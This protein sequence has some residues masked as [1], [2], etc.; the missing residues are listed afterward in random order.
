MDA[1]ADRLVED[2]AGAWR[3]GEERATEKYLADYPELGDHPEAAL[4][5]VYEEVC[6]RQE[7]GQDVEVNRVCHRFPQWESELRVMLDF[8]QLL[9]P[10]APSPVF[11]PVGTVWVGFR[12]LRELGRGAQGRVFLATQPDLADRPVV[13]KLTPCTGQEHMSLARLHHTGIVPLL[14]VKKDPAGAVRTLYMPYHGGVTLAWLLEALKDKPPAQRTG[15]DILRV[16]DADNA[17]SPVPLPRKGTIRDRVYANAS[18]SEAVCLIGALLADALH[19]AHEY[20][21]TGESGLVHLDVKPSNVLLAADGQPMLLD[22]HLAQPPVHPGGPAPEWV[23]GTLAYMPGEQQAAMTAVNGGRPIPEVVDRR[24]DVY[25]LGVTLY[26]ALGGRA[27]FLPG[28]SPPLERCNPAVSPGLSDIVAKCT[29]RLARDRYPNAAALAD[30]LRRHLSHQKLHGAPNRSW[31]ES[32]AKWRRRSPAALRLWAFFLVAVAAV[33]A[34]GFFYWDQ[35]AAR[36]E[37]TQARRTQAAT[38]YR[39]AGDLFTRGHYVPAATAAAH[40]L[41]LVETDA[42][43][44]ELALELLGLRNR[45]RRAGAAQSLHRVAEEIRFRYAAK[46]LSP[47]LQRSIRDK[48][49]AAWA[50]RKQILSKSRA[51]LTAETERQVRTDLL[52]V[53]LIGTDMRVRLASDRRRDRVRREV[54]DVLDE[55]EKLCGRSPAL[56]RE[57]LAHAE[58]L[59]NAALAGHVESSRP[60]TAWDYCLLGR[61]LLQSGQWARAAPAL[62]RAV[63]LEPE[64]FWPNYYQGTCAFRRG[65]WMEAANAF[66]VCLAL[67]PHSTV[68]FYN[69]AQCYVR[70][71]QADE[72]LRDLRHAVKA[73]MDL[74]GVEPAAGYCQMAVLHQE[75]GERAAARQCVTKALAADPQHP[76]AR[77][78]ARQLGR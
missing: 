8:H 27:R 51:K 65:N 3:R 30:D 25:S 47:P 34:G 68:C 61:A 78:L 77:E 63:D 75:R 73:R 46:D 55:A 54:L 24:A 37:Q 16:L 70:L 11:P 22:F 20:K 64:G 62:D 18:Y 2:L 31:Q 13:V 53:A 26:E 32:W 52:D 45:A 56:E 60:R 76:K 33:A 71:K 6:L 29:A 43:A 21:E 42:E 14:D 9:E 41:T 35:A 58:A 4:R 36:D 28:D 57:R 69:R 67:Q 66:R 72:A 39:S 59:G 5:L 49:E 10:P 19:Y 40:G 44:Q 38:D 15:A 7:A 12:L 50:K 1:L 23:G 17:A 48:C 74:V